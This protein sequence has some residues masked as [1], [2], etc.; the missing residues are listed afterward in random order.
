MFAEIVK[1][2]YVFHEKVVFTKT[3]RVKYNYSSY[4]K[5]GKYEFNFRLYWK[6]GIQ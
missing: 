6:W 5:H 3:L 4:L 2:T 1:N